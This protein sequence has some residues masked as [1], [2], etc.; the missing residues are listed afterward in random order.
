M[1]SSA[2]NFIKGHDGTVTLTFEVEVRSRQNSNVNPNQSSFVLKVDFDVLILVDDMLD[3]I[4]LR[5]L[6][7][8]LRAT[9]A[10][11]AG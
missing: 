4:K 11:I 6:R 10:A 5:T 8:R 2:D 7:E 3:P 9:L 1:S